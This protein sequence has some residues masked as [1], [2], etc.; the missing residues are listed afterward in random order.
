MKWYLGIEVYSLVWPQGWGVQAALLWPYRGAA[1]EQC[2]FPG[3]DSRA[4]KD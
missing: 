1:V 4:R 3:Q 2:L